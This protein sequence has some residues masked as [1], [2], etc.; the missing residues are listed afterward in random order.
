MRKACWRCRG[1]AGGRVRWRRQ[2]ACEAP[3]FSRK[4]ATTL[5]LRGRRARARFALDDQWEWWN[6]LVSSLSLSLPPAGIQ[7]ISTRAVCPLPN[8][9]LQQQQS[10]VIGSNI[11]DT[12]LEYF[13]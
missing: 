1:M 3:T 12:A 4:A 8:S 7:A 5:D 13:W 10:Q 11:D 9:I 2:V 6:L